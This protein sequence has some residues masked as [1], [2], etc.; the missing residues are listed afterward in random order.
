MLKKIG[1]YLK[2][3]YCALLNKKCSDDCTCNCE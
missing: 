1:K 2:R 3:L